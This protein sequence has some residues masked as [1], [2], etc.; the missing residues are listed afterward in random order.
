MH[1]CQ[2]PIG[3]NA[4]RYASRRNQRHRLT[5]TRDRRD[6]CPKS[7]ENSVVEI[8]RPFLWKAQSPVTHVTF[9]I[10]SALTD[11]QIAAFDE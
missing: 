5:G 9:D 11:E 7:V 1:L 8:L 2:E 6:V 3:G 10:M 4:E